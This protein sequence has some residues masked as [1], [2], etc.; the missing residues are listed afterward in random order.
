MFK[1]T[2]A[3][4]ALIVAAGALALGSIGTLTGC[5]ATTSAS[6]VPA[7]EASAKRKTEPVR[8]PMPVIDAFRGKGIFY[9]DDSVRT[10]LFIR[11]EIAV[12]G[13]WDVQE[14]F[15]LGSR[16]GFTWG[17][18][19]VAILRDGAPLDA[20]R[21]MF[22]T[23]D[24]QRN[25]LIHFEGG[26]AKPLT[27]RVRLEAYDLS[28]LPIGP[29]LKTRQG[30][31]TAAGYFIGNSYVFPKGAV[32]YRAVLSIDRN[33]VLV[34]TKTAFTGSDSIENFSKRFTKEIPYC[35]RYIPG[36]TAE[37]AG[38]RFAAPI[39]KKTKRV[40]RRVEEVAQSGEVQVLPVKKGTIFCAA[41]GKTQLAS[42]RWNLR[43]V[44]GTRVL[45][46]TFPDE[47][48]SV[49]YGLLD[50]HKRAL[51]LAFAEEK[52]KAGHRTTVKV[53]PAAVWLAGQEIRD[54]QW[55]FNETAA[56]AISDAINRTKA[57]R[58]AWEA[59]NGKTR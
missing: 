17:S 23:L 8:M 16:H 43:W 32:G 47:I 33:E 42:A 3:R 41:E 53:R 6:A 1:H 57:E 48:E 26:G 9:F 5:A 25:V 4:T 28:E 22:I 59:E 40:K 58:R 18:G 52:V 24:P 12:N 50:E 21:P 37:P 10:Q 31:S 38:L 54:A 30:T 34:P 36:T 51:H 29:Y 20:Q 13:R 14:N 45:E 19:A 11:D 27:L 56:D 55:R 35:L 46:F 39:V 15:P 2:F 49:S 44:N 7:S